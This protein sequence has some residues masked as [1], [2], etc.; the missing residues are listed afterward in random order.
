MEQITDTLKKIDSRITD[1]CGFTHPRFLPN[2]ALSGEAIPYLMQAMET[3]FRQTAHFPRPSWSDSLLP[4]LIDWHQVLFDKGIAGIRQ[5]MDNGGFDQL[6]PER[7]SRS[8]QEFG[9]QLGRDT[10]FLSRTRAIAA[11]LTAMADAGRY[12]LRVRPDWFVFDQH[13]VW[14][15]WQAMEKMSVS[16]TDTLIEDFEPGWMHPDLRTRQIPATFNRMAAV[17]G[18]FVCLLLHTL[19]QFPPP[20]DMGAR[21][22]QIDRFRVYN[23]ALSPLLRPF[24]SG[25]LMSDGTGSGM[26]P[27]NAWDRFRDILESTVSRGQRAFEPWIPEWKGDSIYGRNKHLNENEDQVISLSGDAEKQA[28]IGI[29]DGVST[30]DV[31]S[32]WAAA[33][34][35]KLTFDRH[36]R[37][38]K[39]R[40]AALPD[41]AKNPDDWKMQADDMLRTIFKTVHEA[42]IL[43]IESRLSSGITGSAKGSTMSSTL[44]LALIQ[45]NLAR[46]AHWGDSRAY[47]VT[48][49]GM[50]RLTEDHNRLMEIMTSK[51]NPFQMPSGGTAGL[52]R[53]VGSGSIA[54]GS[55]FQPV[56]FDRQKVSIT[57]ITLLPDEMLLLCSDGLP[58]SLSCG[59]EHEKEARM[60]ALIARHRDGSLR[61]LVWH[62]IRLADEDQSNDNIST[63][64]LRPRMPEPPLQKG[65]IHV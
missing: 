29:A 8:L 17:T 41:P 33:A 19:T 49:T 57:E 37:E 21:M 18:T 15:Q 48:A 65:N 36:S 52:I 2:P 46:I 25:M 3:S 54:K 20:R 39:N 9:A 32:G 6:Y 26:T 4:Y 34:T 60:H 35:I 42:V 38:W 45:G 28:L 44:I 55:G 7:E 30:A 62:L 11:A 58:G 63:V 43:E 53:V 47:L 31:G 24:F 5:I 51:K 27:L 1:L 13:R 50:V 12:V 40:L 23:P 56:P 64:I 10:L 16:A 61:D 14:C 22:V 59:N